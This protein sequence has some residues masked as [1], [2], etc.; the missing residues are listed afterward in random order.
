MRISWTDFP[1]RRWNFW[2]WLRFFVL[3]FAGCEVSVLSVFFTVFRVFPSCNRCGIIR[4]IGCLN[5]LFVSLF[6]CF[7]FGEDLLFLQWF[8]GSLWRNRIFEVWGFRVLRFSLCLHLVLLLWALCY[9][10]I[11]SLFKL[12]VWVFSRFVVGILGE[13]KK[14]RNPLRIVVFGILV[15]KALIMSG[16]W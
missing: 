9:C 14:N 11:V 3:S 6:L 4:K 1:W 15:K 5:F 12:V 8:V 13:E 2:M 10:R 7:S 16:V